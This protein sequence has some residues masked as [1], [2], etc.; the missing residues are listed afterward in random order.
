[1]QDIYN[2]EQITMSNVCINKPNITIK[3]IAHT[4][5]YLGQM[6]SIP[7]CCSQSKEQLSVAAYCIGICHFESNN[8]PV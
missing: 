4:K 2:T 7:Q 3:I 6:T 8:L 1:M 5:M